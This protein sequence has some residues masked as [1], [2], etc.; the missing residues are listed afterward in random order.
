[1]AQVSEN[2]RPQ[3]IEN[4]NLII[5]FENKNS[6]PFAEATV[7]IQALAMK[8]IRLIM[9][10]KEQINELGLVVKHTN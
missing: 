10:G 4:N 3:E 7:T 1:M 5:G 6:L 2:E 9:P 8:R